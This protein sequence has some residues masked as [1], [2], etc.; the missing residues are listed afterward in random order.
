MQWGFCLE[1]VVRW[2]RRRKR[3]VAARWEKKRVIRSDSDEAGS[4]LGASQGE[5]TT[6][7]Q[8][9]IGDHRSARRGRQS[10]CCS[11]WVAR[12]APRGF[13][14]GWINQLARPSLQRHSGDLMHQC[15]ADLSILQPLH[16]L[17]HPPTRM[18]RRIFSKC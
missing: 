3:R 9:P 11:W 18:G 6:S 15:V 2:R 13:L 10:T 1:V 17:L 5:P 12:E 14:I 8:N 7:S 4:S 16:T